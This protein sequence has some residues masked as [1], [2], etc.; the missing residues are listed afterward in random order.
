[1]LR[2][3]ANG[4]NGANGGE[5][6]G[7]AEDAGWALRYD[8]D[9]NLVW[10]QG[11]GG[12]FA[13]AY[14]AAGRLARV[15]VTRAG[16]PVSTVVAFAYD[17]FGRRVAKT[18]QAGG[19][20][21]EVRYLWD[22]LLLLG[23]REVVDGAG[24]APKVTT[25]EYLLHHESHEPLALFDE[26]G[27]CTFECD[28][29]GTPRQAF[30]DEG[31]VVWEADLTP[32]GATRARTVNARR[33]P[34]R[35]PGQYA[36]AET[37]LHYSWFRYYDPALRIFER[38]DPMG[39]AGGRNAWNYVP[40]PLAQ[41]DPFGLVPETAP[42]YDVYGLYDPPGPPPVEGQKP[43]Y[44]GITDDQARRAKEHTTTGRLDGKTGGYMAPLA[45]D[46]DYGTAR[47]YEQAYIEKY[48]TKTGVIGQDIS[49]T[50][51]GNKV[52]S[53]DHDNTTRAKARQQHFENA[54]D[55]KMKA[56]NACG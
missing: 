35:L 47:G 38:M 5:A 4:A 51:R 26:A 33:V 2:A 14:D 29:L 39:L 32:F 37:D 45:E 42:G 21:T 44:V 15:E 49:A 6:G 19:R 1:V 36:D 7:T 54:Y 52:N 9:G 53:F 48:E 50:N 34:F 41:T 10:K 17:P 28:H 8:A 24:A 25:R 46:V 22:H 12:T 23:E 27:A 3:G 20:T 16:A 30:D 56:L 11:P 55:K 43:Y 31:R 18:V 40:N 13:F